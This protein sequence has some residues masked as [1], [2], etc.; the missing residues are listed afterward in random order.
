MHRVH[1]RWWLAGLHVK[2][3][4]LEV[5]NRVNGSLCVVTV[6]FQ[7][8][9]AAVDAVI[10][11]PLRGG[12]DWLPGLPCVGGSDAQALC[13]AVREL[14]G[15]LEESGCLTSGRNL[16][17]IKILKA[18]LCEER[19]S[20]VWRGTQSRQQRRCLEWRRCLRKATAF[21]QLKQ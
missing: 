17:F 12:E 3:R 7:I 9:A 6:I 13:I 2:K 20:E 11:E 1:A 5:K 8:E 21:A 15:A 14:K 4:L 16:W 10:S 19:L 18:S